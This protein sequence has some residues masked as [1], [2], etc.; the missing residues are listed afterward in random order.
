VVPRSDAGLSEAQIVVYWRA[1]VYYQ[2]PAVI[3]AQAQRGRAAARVGSI[4][5]ARPGDYAVTGELM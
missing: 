4:I 3:V 2:P 1:K 5:S